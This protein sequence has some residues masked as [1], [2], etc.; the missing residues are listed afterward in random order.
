MLEMFLQSLVFGTLLATSYFA[1]NGL[2]RRA[3]RRRLGT[4]ADGAPLRCVQ[5]LDVLEH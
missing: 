3:A 2:V 5:R 1:V 4:L